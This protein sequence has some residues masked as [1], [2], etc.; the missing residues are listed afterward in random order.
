M[1][2]LN[3]WFCSLRGYIQ[4]STC[5]HLLSQE[6]FGGKSLLFQSLRRNGVGCT[7]GLWIIISHHAPFQPFPTKHE[8][9]A[10]PEIPNKYLLMNIMERILVATR[11]LYPTLLPLRGGTNVILTLYLWKISRN[12]CAQRFC[13]CSI[14]HHAAYLSSLCSCCLPEL[15]ISKKRNHHF[16]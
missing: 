6:I 1:S 14:L 7:L 16:S 15:L 4:V 2:P 11:C 13:S 3:L 9:V 12:L 10:Q 8:W 5:Y